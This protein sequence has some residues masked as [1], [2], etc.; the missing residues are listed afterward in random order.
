M[1][2]SALTEAR[3]WQICRS[4]VFLLLLIMGLWGLGCLAE[5]LGVLVSVVLCGDVGLLFDNL[6]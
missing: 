1:A 3:R 6:V 2:I 5:R 4:G